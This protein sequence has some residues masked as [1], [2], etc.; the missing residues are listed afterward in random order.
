MH[1]FYDRNNLGE[2]LK[3]VNKTFNKILDKKNSEL[4]SLRERIKEL[5]SSV[6][7]IPLRST[8]TEEYLVPVKDI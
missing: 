6:K 2:Q 5:T 3:Y 8:V 4:E 7:Y 1:K